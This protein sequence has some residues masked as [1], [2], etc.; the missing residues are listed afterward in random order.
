M[1]KEYYLL[2]RLGTSRGQE[3]YGYITCSL[4]NAYDMKRL[5]YCNG[6]G[7]DMVGTVFGLWMEKEFQQDLLAIP[8]SEYPDLYGMSRWKNKVH[9]DGACSFDSMRKIMARL[10][11]TVQTVTYLKHGD[12]RS[13][14]VF[15][16]E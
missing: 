7:Y 16:Q 3:T 10:G 1:Q 11:Y 12:E 9:L 15:K 5:A 14:R 4:R 6:G 2:L 13:Y 8:E